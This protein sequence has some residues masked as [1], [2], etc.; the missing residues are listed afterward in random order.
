M[1][2]PNAL[3]ALVVYC[4][5]HEE[6]DPILFFIRLAAQHRIRAVMAARAREERAA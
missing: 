3:A 4:R 1:T 2:E 5:R 6:R